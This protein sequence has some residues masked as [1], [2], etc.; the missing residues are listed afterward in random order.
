[1]PVDSEA[2]QERLRNRAEGRSL[3]PAVSTEMGKQRL[4]LIVIQTARILVR[5]VL[6]KIGGL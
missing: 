4:E 1:M 5:K 6:E 2:S 3:G